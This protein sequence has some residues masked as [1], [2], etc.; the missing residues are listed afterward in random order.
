MKNENPWHRIAPNTYENSEP[1]SSKMRNC[2]AAQFRESR[3]NA[4]TCSESALTAV[5]TTFLLS[6]L[7]MHTATSSK[8]QKAATA[9]RKAHDECPPSNRRQ[10][11]SALPSASPLTACYLSR[12][13]NRFRLQIRGITSSHI[14]PV[15]PFVVAL[16]PA[17]PV[18]AQTIRP[19][20]CSRLRR[21][22]ARFYLDH[23]PPLRPFNHL[24]D[25][26]RHRGTKRGSRSG[27]CVSHTLRFM[28]HVAIGCYSEDTTAVCSHLPARHS[29]RIRFCTTRFRRTERRSFLLPVGYGFSRFGTVSHETYWQA[30][31]GLSW[32]SSSPSRDLRAIA[33]TVGPGSA[34]HQAKAPHASQVERTYELARTP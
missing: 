29:F 3:N 25:K 16:R 34:C 2:L 17:P 12:I 11:R 7:P 4:T 15:S 27:S 5:V 14:L 8:N 26:A 24:A 18:S 33:E 19:L 20:P 6:P 30:L 23:T 28:G 10:K 31:A 21:A 9:V 32:L 22:S 1:E 13:C